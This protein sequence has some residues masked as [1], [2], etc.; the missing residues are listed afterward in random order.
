M[1]LEMFR[2]FLRGRQ[3]CFPEQRSIRSVRWAIFL[4]LARNAVAPVESSR[5]SLEAM[6]TRVLLRW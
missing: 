6:L 5:F 2:Y 3:K 4:L 1:P